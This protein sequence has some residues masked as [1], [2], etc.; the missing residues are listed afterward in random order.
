[1]DCINQ[2]KK[3]A[4]S[5]TLR[6]AVPTTNTTLGSGINRR[7]FVSLTTLLATSAL[8]K[9]E[10]IKVDGGLAPIIDKQIPSRKTK[11]VPP[12][13]GSLKNMQNHCTG[14]QLCVSACPTQVL[15]PSEELESFM[16]PHSS[17][18][19]GYCRPECTK[20]SE[21]CPTGVIRPIDIA[22]KSSIQIGHAVWV[23]ENCVPLTKGD[24]C[25][26]CARHCPSQAITMVPSVANDP[27]SI[28]VPFIN[29]E[30]CIGCG[31]CEY[32]CPSRPFSAIYVEGH[33]QHKII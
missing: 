33:E 7:R 19:R 22:E 30:K 25:G 29:P 11:I 21:V 20:C 13:T 9:A 28:K 6:R 17:Y 14:C 26:N 23:K 8:V 16:Q 27:N 32:L 18:E 5:Y 15:R 24:S 4:I 10:E 2:C 31:A 12:G 1:M 3:G